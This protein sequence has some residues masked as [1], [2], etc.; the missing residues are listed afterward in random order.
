VGGSHLNFPLAPIT[1]PLIATPQLLW[2]DIQINRTLHSLY[3]RSNVEG[4][5]L[6]AVEGLGLI[7]ASVTAHDVAQ[8]PMEDPRDESG[9]IQRNHLR[10]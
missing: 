2:L 8:L 9:V 4:D 5:V 7:F 10:I 3:S 6:E 1:H